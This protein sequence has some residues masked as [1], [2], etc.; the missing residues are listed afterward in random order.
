MTSKITDIL[1]EAA[2]HYSVR[3]ISDGEVTKIR[4]A[5]KCRVMTV[6]T[7]FCEYVDREMLFKAEHDIRESYGFGSVMIKPHFPSKCFNQSVLNDMVMELKRQISTVNGSF[8]NCKWSYDSKNAVVE[9][10]LAHNALALLEE[11]HFTDEFV[12]LVREEFGQTIELRMRVNENATRRVELPPPPPPAPPEKP[13]R[14][15]GAADAPPPWEETPPPPPRPE[16]TGETRAKKVK[17][18][19]GPARLTFEGIPEK[20]HDPEIVFG[21]P[22]SVPAVPM[23]D[24]NP[25]YK[26]VTVYGTIF[27]YSTKDTKAGD[28]IIVSFAVTDLTSSV[29]VKMIAKK[30]EGAFL[31][32][33]GEGKC[34]AV[35]GDY[36]FDDFDHEFAIRP[37]CIAAMKETKRTDNAEVKRVELHLHTN[38]SA[39][40]AMTPTKKLVQRAADWGMPAIAITDHGVAQ[41]FPDAMNA[42]KACKKNGHPIKILY[43]IEAYYIDD[44]VDIV[45]GEDSRP[46]DGEFIVF[47]LETTGLSAVSDPRQVQFFCQS[48]HG[49]TA[50][51]RGADRHYR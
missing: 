40:D 37:Q 36:K 33:L 12:K 39:M 10:E 3:Q 44:M 43:G 13:A 48:P 35:Q 23:V 7:E 46:I 41:A 14:A 30:D 4:F 17:V 31:S 9:C 8:V 6:F 11:K 20:Y 32:S 38:M 51:N 26:K 27:N 28:K 45:K 2:D 5:E 1:I 16:F 15:S 25:N 50:Q 34:V 29:T 19:E 24:L 47:D 18:Q 21:T 49:D 22:K 42:A